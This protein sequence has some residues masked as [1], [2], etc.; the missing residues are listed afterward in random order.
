MLE[1]TANSNFQTH[2]PGTYVCVKFSRQI[3][4]SAANE[5]ESFQWNIKTLSPIP[6]WVGS[7]LKRPYPASMASWLLLLLPLYVSWLPLPFEL[8]RSSVRH[9][10]R[11]LNDFSLKNSV[12]SY[13]KAH[14]VSYKYHSINGLTL[15]HPCILVKPNEIIHRLR[16]PLCKKKF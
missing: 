14:H 1:K 8:V 5:R 11:F 12:Y 7:I 16:L 13:K 3:V 2:K 4:R 15:N 9:L 6:A 10:F